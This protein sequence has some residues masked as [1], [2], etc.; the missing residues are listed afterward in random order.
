MF[1]LCIASVQVDS[2]VACKVSEAQAFQRYCSISIYPVNRHVPSCCSFWFV[3][4]QQTWRWP[5]AVTILPLPQVET[6]ASF[7]GQMQLRARWLRQLPAQTLFQHVAPPQSLTATYDNI[8]RKID[9]ESAA[10]FGPLVPGGIPRRPSGPRKARHL[11]QNPHALIGRSRRHVHHHNSSIFCLF[12]LDGI[13]P[14][15]GDMVLIGE[16][17]SPLKEL[18]EI[19]RAVL[20]EKKEP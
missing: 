14:Y 7:P 16:V 3:M 17:H 2:G 13:L 9:R 12:Q 10:G 4:Q 18:H 8:D 11:L 20:I 19:E 6:A 15:H 5:A 1:A